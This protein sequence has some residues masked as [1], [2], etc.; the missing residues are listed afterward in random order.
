MN[1]KK[2]SE[3]QATPGLQMSDIV[4][5][6]TCDDTGKLHS[7][8]GTIE[9]VK[10]TI[11]FNMNII[12]VVEVDPP[13]NEDNPVWLLIGGQKVK[14]QRFM[15][16][17]PLVTF[18]GNIPRFI[19]AVYSFRAAPGFKYDIPF[20]V[21]NTEFSELIVETDEPG[22]IVELSVTQIDEKS[23]IISFVTH[24][25]GNENSNSRIKVYDVK[26]GI[27]L[28]ITVLHSYRF[29]SLRASSLTVSNKNKSIHVSIDSTAL[30]L[31]PSTTYWG[32]FQ[33]QISVDAHIK[34]KTI[35][36]LN[37]FGQSAFSRRNATYNTVDLTMIFDGTYSGILPITITD[38][39]GAASV[40]IS[41]KV[42]F[43]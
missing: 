26:S 22:R 13:E 16:E 40:S 3:L 21:L 4:P 24:Y 35:I 18:P 11:E 41:P 15:T 32:V 42:N 28:L 38:A 39:I 8:V 12:D 9:Q 29:S 17:V 14:A 43:E 27:F 6:V 7:M 36:G 5:I 2:F 34:F 19:P 23:G 31:S 1:L 20:V 33:P 10:D 37:Y 25:Q 30:P